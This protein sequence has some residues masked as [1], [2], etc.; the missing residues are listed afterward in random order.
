MLKSIPEIDW[1][2][3]RSSSL[4]R[5][6]PAALAYGVIPGTIG[7]GPGQGREKTSLLANITLSWNSWPVIGR[8]FG[9]QPEAGA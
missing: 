2:L 7:K 5:G 8:L 9:W 4:S 1:E 6:F 3:G